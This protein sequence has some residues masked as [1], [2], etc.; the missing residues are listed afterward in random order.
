MQVTQNDCKDIEQLIPKLEEQ[1]RN[2]GI[3]RSNPEDLNDL[4]REYQARIRA[5]VWALRIGCS[6][7]D[8]YG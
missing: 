3:D 8:R 7:P 1:Q 2:A 4:N 6:N 5:A